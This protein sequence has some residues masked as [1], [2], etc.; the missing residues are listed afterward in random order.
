MDTK[1]LLPLHISQA[2]TR[3]TARFPADIHSAFFFEKI[4]HICDES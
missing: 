2:A 4:I 1:K 3:N